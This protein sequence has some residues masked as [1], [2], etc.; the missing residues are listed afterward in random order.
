MRQLPVC[1]RLADAR[2]VFTIDTGS[3]GRPD[4]RSQLTLDGAAIKMIAE[5]IVDQVPHD[6]ESGFNGAAIQ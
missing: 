3:G 2:M 6:A 5:I 4:R 1:P